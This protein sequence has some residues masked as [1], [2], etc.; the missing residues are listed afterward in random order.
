M[1]NEYKMTSQLMMSWAKEYHLQGA[2]NIISFII[3]CV[4]GVIGL[5]M[6]VIAITTGGEWT[7][8]YF[9]ILALFLSVFKLFIARFITMSNRYKMMSKTYGVSEWIRSTE[10]TDDEIIISDHTSITRLRYD[11]IKKIKDKDNDVLIIFNN[12]LGL[13]LY[14]DA[15]VEGTWDECME[16][17]NSIINA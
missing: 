1:K 11:N 8:W 15:F 14:K 10:F 4:V 9:S 17:I 12:N 13:R 5:G 16:K 7:T 3:W 2:A 6:L